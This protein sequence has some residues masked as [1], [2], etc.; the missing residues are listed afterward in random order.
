MKTTKLFLAFFVCF[1]FVFGS[2]ETKP[3]IIAVTEPHRIAVSESFFK[4]RDSHEL[5]FAN[6]YISADT[7]FTTYD[8]QNNDRV[9]IDGNYYTNTVPQYKPIL[10]KKTD[11]GKFVQNSNNWETIE[12]NFRND[13]DEDI[14]LTFKRAWYTYQYELESAK[15]DKI[16]LFLPTFKS[17]KPL[18]QIIHI[19]GPN[20]NPDPN[21][22]DPGEGYSPLSSVSD[23][24]NVLDKGNLTRADIPTITDFICG[25]NPKIPYSAPGKIF[26]RSSVVD[27]IGIYFEEAEREGINPDLAIAQVIQNLQ[28]FSESKKD[29]REAHNYGAIINL[30]ANGYWTGSSFIS[31]QIGIRAHIQFLKRSV[32]GNLN[33]GNTPIVLPRT[34]W[35]DLAVVAGTR[36]TLDG[37]SRS[38]GGSLYASKVKDIYKKLF[39]YVSARR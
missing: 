7:E 5:G 26:D 10:I 25:Q 11:P 23:I 15:I 13:K 6:F 29:F 35:N 34:I 16:P 8:N 4:T 36:K 21:K 31:R 30:K 9:G 20:P 18:L 27:I 33:D 24:N 3:E 38:W 19:S 2:C 22:R 28:Y 37:I 12:V 32:S 39:V 17:D 1:T 14:I